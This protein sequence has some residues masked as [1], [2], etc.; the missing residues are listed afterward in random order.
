[1]D[2]ILMLRIRGLLQY[3]PETPGFS[4]PRH[5]ECCSERRIGLFYK[6]DFF[7]GR[8]PPEHRVAVRKSPEPVDYCLVP[9]SIVE[10]Q[11]VFQGTEKLNRAYL[12]GGIFAVLE[13][14]I[15]EFPLVYRQFPVESAHQGLVGERERGAIR[16]KCMGGAP[17]H[18]AW[19]LIEDDHSRQAT[20]R[21]T[22]PGFGDLFPQGFMQFLEAC[23]DVAV[24]RFLA[25]EPIV[26][27]EL[28][29]PEPEN[30]FNSGRV[31]HWSVQS[32]LVSTGN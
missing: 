7:R 21:A 29:E 10:V 9:A 14:H 5:D 17:V 31:F 18:V 1:M 23:A 2:S 12:I 30:L 22:P 4:V 25:L 20:A 3:F 26:W 8:Y 24:N 27:R 6:L 13:R 19:K 16:G 28:V 32:T 11:F 15:Q